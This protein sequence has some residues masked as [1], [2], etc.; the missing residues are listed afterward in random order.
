MSLPIKFEPPIKFD[1]DDTRTSHR[2]QTLV[3]YPNLTA[4]FHKDYPPPKDAGTIQVT[5]IL[6]HSSRSTVYLGR[7]TGKNIPYDGE[8]AIKV[9]DTDRLADEVACY[10]HLS[11]QQGSIIPRFFG[12]FRNR[13][14]F[15]TFLAGIVLE[16]FGDRLDC[17]FHDLQRETKCLILH[18]LSTIHAAGILLEDFTERNILIRGREVRF[19][20][21]E[22]VQDHSCHSAYN[23][24]NAS[25]EPLFD[26]LA[27]ICRNIRSAAFEMGFWSF[28]M[29]Q[30]NGTKFSTA[31]GLP[32][33]QSVIDMLHPTHLL[34]K[35]DRFE[36]RN[37]LLVYYEIV[38]KRMVNGETAKQLRED[39][40]R[41]MEEAE[42]QWKERF[43]R[44][45][46]AQRK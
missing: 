5:G 11:E 21:F 37:L 43:P 35:Y 4:A 45:A 28:P 13:T 6:S 36:T 40:K 29:V 25:E 8:L 33:D 26:E 44:M 30:I 32:R 22:D 9:G 12:I 24:L 23:F 2:A 38:R 7:F 3:D 27:G 42:V 14:R 34:E 1:L 10:A 17:L 46:E 18:N 41:V 20:D 15:G 16:R 19:I 39:M 31:R